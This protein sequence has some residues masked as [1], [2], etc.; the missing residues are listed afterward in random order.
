MLQIFTDHI[1]P[2]VASLILYCTLGPC[3]LLLI[4][5]NE[6]VRLVL[7]TFLAIKYS[8]SR[9]KLVSSGTDGIFCCNEKTTA[10]TTLICSR[11]ETPN[12]NFQDFMNALQSRFID[13]KNEHGVHPYDKFKWIMITKFGYPCWKLDEQFE[14]KNHV[15]KVEGNKSEHDLRNYMAAVSNDM[16]QSR[17][18]WEMVLYYYTGVSF[19]LQILYE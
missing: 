19:F 2:V 15:R 11:F 17:P 12:V 9:L 3:V 18:Q 4:I 10:A 6:L 7:N 16:N 1:L 5:I 14:L 13:H 8:H